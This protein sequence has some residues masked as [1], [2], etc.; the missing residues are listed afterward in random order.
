[1]GKKV[2]EFWG[3]GPKNE[4]V[5][6]EALFYD[7]LE[8]HGYNRFS[9]FGVY[10]TVRLIKGVA[11]IKTPQDVFNDTLVFIKKQNDDALRTCWMKQ[12]E[13]MLI[14]R[15]AILGS[16]P[17][18][19]RERY[20]DTKEEV[21]IFYRNTIAV[22]TPKGSRF[23]SYKKF[24]KSGQFIFGEQIIQRNFHS[25]I[26]ENG[27]FAKFSSVVTNDKKHLLSYRTTLG[28]LISTYKNPSIARAVIVS[29]MQSQ[30]EN[31]AFG[32]SGKGIFIK[33]LS[34]MLQIA[35]YNG[36]ATDLKHD[37]FV[38]QNVDSLT[39]LMVL[40]DVSKDFVFESL[41]STLTDSMSIER[42]YQ[43]KIAIPFS[44]SP[45]IALTTNYTIPQD[46]DSYKDRKHLV[47]LNNFFNAGNKP[48]KHFKRMLFDWN[49]KE[50]AKFD[51]YMA[52]CVRLFLEKGLVSFVDKQFE[53]QKLINQTSEEFVELIESQYCLLNQYFKIKE[54][55]KVLDV[56]T[57]DASS[58]SRVVGKWIDLYAAYKGHQVERRISGGVVKI[59]FRP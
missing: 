53:R 56:G 27:D 38:Y 3:L 18:L 12:G 21:R 20:M 45:K 49:E 6:K 50:W 36:K 10:V 31:E 7:F 42:K 17:E 32:R 40:Q 5:F 37:K 25:D 59:C 54:I 43:S 11:F 28:Y 15:K 58:K 22:I 13:D 16:L 48:E 26:N 57:E 23:E 44:D 34:H 47:M 30:I 19:N 41:F 35:E 9:A 46:S 8:L 52:E 39:S 1:M 2:R 33:S 14:K 55:A 51:N 4:L 29:D 24:K